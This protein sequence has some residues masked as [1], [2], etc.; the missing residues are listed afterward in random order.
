M[1]KFLLFTNTLIAVAVSAF[2]ANPARIVDNPY[3]NINP[4]EYLQLPTD[5]FDI[6]IIA[7]CADGL[8]F[9]IIPQ[10]M[11]GLYT[12]ILV[13]ETYLTVD[14]LDDL[15]FAD[16]IINVSNQMLEITGGLLPAINAEFFYIGPIETVAFGGM[17]PGQRAFLAVMGVEYN[18]E[19]NLVY[20]S[21][22]VSR[23]EVFEFTSDLLPKEEPYATFGTPEYIKYAGALTVRAEVIPNE[24]A[25]D[26]V[27]GKVFPADY[28]KTHSDTEIIDYLTSTSNMFDTWL[29]PMRLDAELEPGQQA[30][31]A[32]ATL[33]KES[34]RKSNRLNWMIVEAPAAAGDPVI[35]IDSADATD[36]VISIKDNPASL[37]DGLW[38]LDGKPVEPSSINKGI[39]ILRQNNRTS[40]L[41]IK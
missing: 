20:P 35:I 8:K 32:V 38:T 16:Q 29:Y 33:D 3:D 34:G 41:I 13:D 24:A 12:N 31:F 9:S 27:Y 5:Q 28:R 10:D 11:T 1:K 21:T 17:R 4:E 26:Y 6:N 23:S 25:G 7:A 40:K 36:G 19:T 22:Q 2:A 15:D 18:E 30:L 39:Y 14:G 37:P